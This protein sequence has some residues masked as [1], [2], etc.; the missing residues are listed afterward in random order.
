MQHYPRVT[1]PVYKSHGLSGPAP[2]WL[3]WDMVYWKGDDAYLELATAGDIPIEAR[4]EPR[5]WWG[6]TEVVMPGEGQEE[7]RD[8]PAEFTAPLFDG[9]AARAPASRE[10]LARLYR[11]ALRGVIEKWRAGSMTDG[12]A[13]F[14][15]HFVRHRL[16]PITLEAL[17]EVAPLVAEYRH[18]EADVPVPVRAPGLTAGDLHQQTL[19]VRGNHKQP[20][21]P[22]ARRFLEAFGAPDYP[23]D[24]T[25]RLEL[26]RDLVHPRNPLTA[27][28]AVNRIWHWVFGRGLVE[29]TDNFGRLGVEPSH[30]ELL[31]WLA[32]RFIEDGWRTK[33]LIRLLVTSRTFRRSSVAADEA[34]EKDPGNR[35]LARGSPRRLEAEAIRDAILSVSGRL[36]P[37]LFGP[38]VG[39][40]SAR[41]SVYVAVR[42]NSLSPFLEVFDAPIPFTTTGRRA[43]TNV[44]AQSLALMNSPFVIEG[45][46][47]WAERLAGDPTLSDDR[48]RVGAHVPRSS[49]ARG[50]GRGDPERS[51]LR[52]RGRRTAEE[53][54]A[55]DR[56]TRARDRGAAD[57]CER[58][59]RRG[60]GARARGSRPAGGP[61]GGAASS[62]DRALGFRRRP[63][64]LDRRDARRAGRPAA[65]RGRKTAPRRKELRRDETAGPG[66]PRE[67]PR[68]LG[69]ARGSRSARGRRDHAPD[70]GWSHLRLDRLRG[71]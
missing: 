49:R 65:S 42:R 14:L 4:D 12:E 30:P 26:A 67:D 62:A 21:D 63:R 19:F 31:D 57:A 71:A 23:A 5:S 60:P 22:V 70:E 44:P 69:R 54:P 2:R 35:L 8:E 46:S 55:G 58:D 52:R 59:A 11:N 24:S 41:R 66:H 56:A 9:A 34:R 61:R 39:D 10:D 51:A 43:V 64:R 6:I 3:R 32:A 28:V 40:G 29:T 13:R 25:G 27:R 36:D 33:R 47:R 53:N 50:A 37:T 18:L 20:G 17:P 38:P 48:D 16:L 7:P 1:G 45:A 68:G 15:D